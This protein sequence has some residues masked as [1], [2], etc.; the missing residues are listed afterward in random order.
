MCTGIRLKAK[1]GS[2]VCARTLE[3]GVEINSQIIFLPR[4]YPCVGTVPSNTNGLT[5]KSTYAAVGTNAN[6]ITGIIDGVNEHGLAGGLFY[7]YEYAQYQHVAENELSQ[8][9]APWHLMTWILTTCKTVAEV[10]QKLP[11]LKVANIVFE[12]WGFV[13]PVHAVVHDV[14]GQSLVIEYVNGT[15]HMHTN[16]L[17]VVTNA[18]TFDW[19]MTNLKNYVRLSALNV[20][21]QQLDGL[22]LT[23]LGQGSGMLGL[24]GDFT[25]PSRFVR[26]AAFSATALQPETELDAIH[27]A[28]HILNLFDIPKGTVRDQEQGRISCE[29]TQWTSATDLK[30]KR[31]Y[32]HTY[33]SRIPAVI[34]L[35]RMDLDAKEICTVS[36]NIPEKIHDSTP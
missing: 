5:W 25:S 23:P 31:Y 13:P 4:N 33:A 29:Y 21:N 35:L 28:F 18:P 16:I 9:I 24:P 14:S 3:F 17:G 34:D 8:A 36:M 15:L 20:V 6:N 26:A 1:N 7:F 32:F 12:E 2:V 30:N 10:Q 19:H 11:S 22:T 27:T